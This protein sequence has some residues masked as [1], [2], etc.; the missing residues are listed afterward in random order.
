[1]SLVRTTA[2]AAR[3]ALVSC[4]AVALTVHASAARAQSEHGG[5]PWNAPERAAHRANP[6]LATDAAIERGEMIFHQNCELCHGAKGKGNGPMSTSLPTK[7]ADLTSDHVQVQTDG[8]LFWKIFSGRGMMP[9]TQATL[10]DEQRWDVVDFIRTL[11]A[12]RQ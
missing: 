2:T 1:M 6:V 10:S 4:M 12:K 8:A 5:T 3:A 11:A 7:P 9:T